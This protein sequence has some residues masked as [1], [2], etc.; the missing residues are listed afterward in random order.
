MGAGD[1]LRFRCPVFPH[2]Q[3]AADTTA[4][5]F[6]V[7]ISRHGQTLNHCDAASVCDLLRF[8]GR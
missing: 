4:L 2:L 7:G 5:I 8:G 6:I 3:L 1:Q